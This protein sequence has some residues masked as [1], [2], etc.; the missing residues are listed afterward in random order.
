MSD[1]FLFS[2]EYFLSIT[3]SLNMKSTKSFLKLIILFTLI[4]LS[5]IIAQDTIDGT[6]SLIKI[7]DAFNSGEVSSLGEYIDS[8]TYFSFTSDLTG[9]YSYSQ[10]YNLLKDYFSAY[11]PIK[12]KFSSK[13]GESQT[14]FGWG[15]YIYLRNGIRGSHK[16]FISLQKS[17]PNFY[18][19]QISIN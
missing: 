10:I 3:K 1:A 9:Y 12:F 16:I 6:K 7:E 5:S 2:N 18:I 11:T 8:K 4:F 13:Q 14:P 17:G 15:E 19:S